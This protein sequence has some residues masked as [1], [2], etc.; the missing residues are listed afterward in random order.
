MQ[1]FNIME[2]AGISQIKERGRKDYLSDE[3]KKIAEGLDFSFYDGSREKGFGG[4]Y[5]DGRWIKVAEVIRDRY[6][7]HSGSKVLID[8]CH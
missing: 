6:G 8:R 1:E 5:Y 7:L 3:D 2:E 4:Y